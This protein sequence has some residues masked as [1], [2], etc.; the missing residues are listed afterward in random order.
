VSTRPVPVPDTVSAAYWSAAAAR[1]LHIARCSVC[2][3]YS[4]PPGVTCQRC[5]STTPDYSFHPVSGEGVLRSWTVVRQPFL[6]GFD[7]LPFVL[8]DVEL[9]EQDE[10]RMIG[11]LLDGPEVGLRIGMAVRVDFED[12][13]DGVL[14]PAFRLAGDA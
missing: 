12:L 14:V 1:E 7:D 2:E 5:G 8:A 9:V 4:V 10:L 13:G 6:P 11:R 3:A